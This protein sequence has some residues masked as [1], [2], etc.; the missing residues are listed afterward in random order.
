M[1]PLHV[2]DRP[3]PAALPVELGTI[4]C[5]CGGKG[6]ITQNGLRYQCSTCG[7]SGRITVS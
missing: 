5:T 7:G 3:A 2:L 6:Y 1:A 4:P